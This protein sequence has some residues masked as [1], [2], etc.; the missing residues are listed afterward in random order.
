MSEPMAAA[1]ENQVMVARVGWPAALIAVTVAVA[2]SLV[3]FGVVMWRTGDHPR[4]FPAGGKYTDDIGMTYQVTGMSVVESAPPS[5]RG[6][7]D[8]THPPYGA[9]FVRVDMTVENIS[10]ETEYLATRCAFT[11]LGTRG[12]TWLADKDAG[13][14]NSCDAELG[15]TQFLQIYYAVPSSMLDEI[16]GVQPWHVMSFVQPPLLTPPPS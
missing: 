8:L 15:S 11:M 16:R 7:G 13:E 14:L 4:P 3:W 9:M 1:S 10:A 5:Y 6:G 2:L 12:Q